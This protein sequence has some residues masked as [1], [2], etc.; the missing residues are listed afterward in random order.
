MRGFIFAHR[1]I[2]L[3]AFLYL[4][5]MSQNHMHA[6]RKHFKENG[7]MPGLINA[8]VLWTIANRL[9]SLS[10]L[11]HNIFDD[12]ISR[13]LALT[14][15]CHVYFGRRRNSNGHHNFSP[16]FD[17]VVTELEEKQVDNAL[18]LFVVQCGV[19]FQVPGI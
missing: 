13:M 15:P 7:L 19:Y 9:F 4:F 6:I 3:H 11:I 16:E 8:Y 5:D 1:R 17:T 14:T 10:Q 2:C 12:H 18:T